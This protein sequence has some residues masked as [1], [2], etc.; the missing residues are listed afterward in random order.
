MSRVTEDLADR[1]VDEWQLG[2]HDLAL[3]AFDGLNA[4]EAVDLA[5]MVSDRLIL[6]RDSERFH[7]EIRRRAAEVTARQ[8]EIRR[9]SAARGAR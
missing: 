8:A 4:W 1:V 7:S 3:K 5:L 6:L 2:R 9:S